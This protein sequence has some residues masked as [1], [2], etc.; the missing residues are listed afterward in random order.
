L[1]AMGREALRLL[2]SSATPKRSRASA[3]LQLPYLLRDSAVSHPEDRLYPASITLRIS[4]ANSRT[5]SSSVSHEH[6]NRAP[7]L[8]IKV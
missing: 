4:A 7:P 3:L 5:R 6:M 2:W 8:P 1:P